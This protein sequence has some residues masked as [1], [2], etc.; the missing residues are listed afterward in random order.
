[1]SLRSRVGGK[2]WTGL[3]RLDD[4]LLIR[5]EYSDEILHRNQREDR[6]LECAC[7]YLD[8]ASRVVSNELAQQKAAV[9]RSLARTRHIAEMSTGGSVTMR[10]GASAETTTES[11]NP[12]RRCLNGHASRAVE[13]NSGGAAVV[14]S[15]TRSTCGP[16]VHQGKGSSVPPGKTTFAGEK[17]RTEGVD[18]GPRKGSYN[19]PLTNVRRRV[20]HNTD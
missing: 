18:T 15:N 9:V 5:S 11:A 7:R 16:S 3:R 20:R 4:G 12:N 6:K 19:P 13:A 14:R 17:R 1:M 8:R 10:R 2:S